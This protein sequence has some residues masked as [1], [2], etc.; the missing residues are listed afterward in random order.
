MDIH[1]I[2]E[3]FGKYYY[4]WSIHED[5]FVDYW[6]IWGAY[7]NVYKIPAGKNTKRIFSSMRVER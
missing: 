7:N 2:Q 4:L 5:N 6:T 3:H 1:W